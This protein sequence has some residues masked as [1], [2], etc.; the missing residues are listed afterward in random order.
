[1]A[2]AEIATRWVFNILCY[3]PLWLLTFHIVLKTVTLA[4][5]P[6]SQPQQRQG[7]PL[8]HPRPPRRGRPS[9]Q[10]H[11]GE[12]P[13]GCPPLALS[14]SL[15]AQ[16]LKTRNAM[17]RLGTGALVLCVAAW[18]VWCSKIVEVRECTGVK[19]EDLG[20]C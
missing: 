13:P 17:L 15:S 8:P 9:P 1:V 5:P 3:C 10:E 18:A 6:Q 19:L 16:Q 12:G 2:A 20:E 11:R 7:A 14:F 4:E